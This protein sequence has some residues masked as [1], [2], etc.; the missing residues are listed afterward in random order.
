MGYYRRNLSLKKKSKIKFAI[1]KHCGE[2]IMK[3]D[4]DNFPI[5]AVILECTNCF[6]KYELNG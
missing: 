2:E 1:C 6:I 5:E 4:P 3:Y